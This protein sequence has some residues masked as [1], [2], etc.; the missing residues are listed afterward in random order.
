MSCGLEVKYTPTQLAVDFGNV[1]IEGNVQ[2]EPL[3]VTENGTYSEIGVAY[4]PVTVDVAGLVPTGTLEITKNGTYDVTEKASA[5]V[6]VPQRYPSGGKTITKNGR[7]SVAWLAQA[8]V[9]VPTFEDKIT[10][11]LDGTATRLT[12]LPSGLAKIKPYAFYNPVRKLPNGSSED[13]DSIE[14][15]DLAVTE[16]GAY[17]FFNNTLSSL[18]LRANQIVTIADHA[19]DGTSIASGT[20]I[21]RV[22]ASLVAAYEAQYP[23][24]S[25]ESIP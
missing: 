10:A 1:T 3:A 18:T 6:S 2:V 23:D 15:A 17:A 14:F 16:I 4:S 13:V 19:L 20:G 25:F 7:T 24:W 12:G 5:H 21:I 9:E 11:I 22:P 8:F